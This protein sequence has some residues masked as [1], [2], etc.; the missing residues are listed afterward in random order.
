MRTRGSAV[1]RTAPAL[2]GFLATGALLVAGTACQSQP[3]EHRPEALPQVEAPYDRAVLTALSEVPGTTLLSVRVTDVSSPNPVWLTRV[4][5][6]N[7]T[8]HA[9]R[10]DAI[11][12]RFLG[13]SV[14]GDQG[15][16]QKARMAALIAS[17]KVLPHDAVDKVKQPDFGKVTDVSLEKDN[18]G[19][20]VWSVTID[21]VQGGQTHVYQ[22]DAVT[23][24]VVHSS[25]VPGNSSVPREPA[26]PPAS[27]SGS[28]R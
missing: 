18:Q 9:V 28:P 5:E 1:G 17:A 3:P 23:S 4:A 11:H 14:P 8:V 7:G 26:S 15:Q 6:Q 21:T 22:I 13:T 20:P 25:T 16:A 19:R 10:V 2:A 12:G 27:S 24:K